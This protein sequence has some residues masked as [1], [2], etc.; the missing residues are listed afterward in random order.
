MTG[1]AT[2]AST[3]A[4]VPLKSGAQAKSRLAGVLDPEQRAHLFFALAKHVI[5]TLRSC[6]SI[7]A[8]AVVTSSTEVAK[9]ATALGAMPILQRKDVGMSP[10]LLWAL[11]GLQEAQPRRVLML[12][13]DLPLISAAA[14]NAMVDA[15]DT[16]ASVVIAPDR[17]REGTNALLCSPPHALTPR[18]GHRSFERHLADAR[19]QGLVTRILE[20]DELALDLD[21]LDDL[22]H[23]RLHGGLRAQHLLSGFHPACVAFAE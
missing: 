6:E 12:P 10:A 2:P 7:D 4:L 21:C 11:H 20:V 8:V 13:G 1:I 5:A 15:A 14:V 17:H 18:F 16:G 19:A 23:L 9:F 22:T 3:W